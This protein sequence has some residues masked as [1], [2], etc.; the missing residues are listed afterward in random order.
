M[1]HPGNQAGF[2]TS[3][4]IPPCSGWECLLHSMKTIRSAP[5]MDT[6]IRL[7]TEADLDDF[8]K[9]CQAHFLD[10]KEHGA[11]TVFREGIYPARDDAR[12]ALQQGSLYECLAG[13]VPAAFLMFDTCQ[14]REYGNIRWGC[15]FPADTV[16]V[17]HLLIVHPRARGRGVGRAMVGFALEEARQ[18]G[19]RA[20]RLD[21]GLQNVPACSLYR[22]MGFRLAA[23]ASMEVGGRIH[24]P[25]H[26]FLEKCL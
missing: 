13:S 9:L 6:S 5:A 15:P 16:A 23:R 10:E 19:C 25:G 1:G 8:E 21:T 2:P 18:R 4:Y 17:I 7:A 24:H 22:Q 11:Y 12:I 20:V 26:L 3:I 14:P